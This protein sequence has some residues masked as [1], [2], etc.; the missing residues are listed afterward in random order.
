MWKK[1]KPLDKK[2]NFFNKLFLFPT[3]SFDLRFWLLLIFWMPF[4]LFEMKPV[5]V[6]TTIKNKKF[7]FN[8][9]F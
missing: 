4:C 3:A 7:F 2:K 5:E 9:W 8:F 6:K 1:K